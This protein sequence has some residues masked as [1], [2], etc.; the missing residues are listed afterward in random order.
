MKVP[1]NDLGLQHKLLK[2]E[3]EESF[4]KIID[5]SSCWGRRSIYF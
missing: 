5:T 1:F 2:Q 3:V 4:K